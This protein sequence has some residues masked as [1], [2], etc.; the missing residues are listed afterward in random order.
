[1][2]AQRPQVRAGVRAC[3]ASG[4]P[5]EALVI[6]LDLARRTQEGAL[7]APV[8]QRR[9]RC[10]RAAP[11]LTRPPATATFCFE[12]GAARSPGSRPTLGLAPSA[13]RECSPAG[14]TLIKTR[15]RSERGGTAARGVRP[16]R[17][18]ARA[19]LRRAG[20]PTNV[21]RHAE[22]AARTCSSTTARRHPAVPD[23]GRT[24]RASLPARHHGATAPPQPRPSPRRCV[25][26]RPP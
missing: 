2:R 12:I 15:E 11:R 8:E 5:L 18:P 24:D 14:T 6:A 20:A 22:A 1:M 26:R 4:P 23:D 7:P 17:G 19:V 10:R 3:E 13:F 16:P 21:I 9:R 25:A